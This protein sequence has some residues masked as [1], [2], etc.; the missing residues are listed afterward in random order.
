MKS[1]MLAGDLAES[2]L[3]VGETLEDVLRAV[4]GYPVTSDEYP[5]PLESERRA[6]P[7]WRST[8]RPPVR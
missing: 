2:L 1:F 4:A 8:M 5:E 3:Y 7:A 6:A